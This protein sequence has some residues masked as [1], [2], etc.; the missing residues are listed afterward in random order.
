MITS[1]EIQELRELNHNLRFLGTVMMQ[2]LHAEKSKAKP[3]YTLD[4]LME[5][6]NLPR[7]QI[8]ALFV[9]RHGHV[10]RRGVSPRFPLDQVLEMD[11]YLRTGGR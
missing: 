7:G 4:E 8:V 3:Q 2:L 9:R 10:P 6:W 5:R 11:E 1:I